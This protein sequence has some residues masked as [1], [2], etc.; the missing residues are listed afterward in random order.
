LL[1]D[2][3][4]LLLGGLLLYFGAEWLV[5]GAAGIAAALRVRPLVIGLTV[6]AYGTSAPE[7]VVGISA[8]LSG[9]GGIAFGNA[10]GS[11]IANIGLILGLAALISPPRVDPSLLRR[12]VPTMVLSA[13]A[14][15]LLLLDGRVSRVE[16]AAL[17]LGAAI[18]T[19]VMLRSARTTT[20]AVL[21]SAEVA[22][23]A[24][25]AAAEPPRES[26]VRLAVRAIFGLA[27]LLVGGRWL[28]DG[29]TGIATHYGVS[30]R[31]VGLTIVSIGTSLPELAISLIAARR[32][33]SDIA[34]GNVVGSNIFNVL[35]ILGAS[36]LAGPLDVSLSESRLDIAALIVATL[37][38]ALF[39]RGDRKISRPE[40]A[41]LVLLYVAFL[42]ALSLTSRA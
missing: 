25:E 14:V 28:V 27:L 1:L 24:R 4:F 38:A 22:E 18:Y 11:N 42:M 20:A 5:R 17:L 13:L 41:V 30:E 7:L 21:A 12:E 31:L 35:L 2:T 32:G 37:A 33:H 6:V 36:G 8:A 26:V 39:L 23:E 10:I 9:R 29:A 19:I 15:P 34:V 16:G 40:G 3:V